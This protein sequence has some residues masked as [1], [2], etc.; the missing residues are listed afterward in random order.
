MWLSKIGGNF[1]IGKF[2][3]NRVGNNKFFKFSEQQIGGGGDWIVEY[4]IVSY[5]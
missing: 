3:F 4:F 1:E 5:I 2:S